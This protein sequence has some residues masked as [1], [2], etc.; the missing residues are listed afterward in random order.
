MLSSLLSII[1]GIVCGIGALVA[2]VLGYCYARKYMSLAQTRKNI[3]SRLKWKLTHRKSLRGNFITK[4]DTP[5]ENTYHLE[6]K[7]FL[8]KGSFGVVVVGTHRETYVQY[9]IK[10]VVKTVEK[11]HRIERELR[12]LKDVDHVN[13]VAFHRAN[14]MLQRHHSTHHTSHHSIHA[15]LRG[16]SV[17]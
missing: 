8:G 17:Q 11:R 5:I 10:C 9:A 15:V 1:I 13:I 2:I 14:Y 12:L 4:F 16:Q 7:Y 6:N 3:D